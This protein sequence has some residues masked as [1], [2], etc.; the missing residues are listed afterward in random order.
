MNKERISEKDIINIEK[1]I[2]IKELD[3][4]VAGIRDFD[5][6][7]FKIKGWAITV[8]SA[9]MVLSVSENAPELILFSALSSILFWIFEAQYKAYQQRFIIRENEIKRHLASDALFSRRSSQDLSEE[10]ASDDFKAS[11]SFKD[12]GRVSF[13]VERERVESKWGRKL[14][15]FSI[16]KSDDSRDVIVCMWIG[17]VR[18][19]YIALIL[20]TAPVFFVISEPLPKA[21]MN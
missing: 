19:I 6:I 14:A 15:K 7:I 12:Y 21:L 13:E 9:F 5:I 20:L 8:F 11:V 16:F 18:F 1:E 10:G 4:C 17:N 3:Y 2:I